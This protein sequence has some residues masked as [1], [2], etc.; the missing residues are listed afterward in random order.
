MGF[1]KKKKRKKTGLSEVEKP[2]WWKK[3]ARKSSYKNFRAHLSVYRRMYEVGT[4]TMMTLTKNFAK[5]I[6]YTVCK[7]SQRLTID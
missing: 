2:I 5:V 6:T 7:F 3:Y 1:N 4:R